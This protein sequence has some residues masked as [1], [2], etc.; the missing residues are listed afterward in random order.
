MPTLQNFCYWLQQ[1]EALLKRA[2]TVV[3]GVLDKWPC[4]VMGLWGMWMSAT[5]AYSRWILLILVVPVIL[6]I[7]VVPVR[8]QSMKYQHMHSHHTTSDQIVFVYAGPLDAS[9]Q[10]K[11]FFKKSVSRDAK[12]RTQTSC[13]S[14]YSAPL[15][16]YCTSLWCTIQQQ[17]GLSCSKWNKNKYFKGMVTLLVGENMLCC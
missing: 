3:S 5:Q 17:S 2:S 4:G 12:K 9:G 14:Q 8:Q 16:S 10:W 13:R 6:L 15:H 1:L 11:K 7:L